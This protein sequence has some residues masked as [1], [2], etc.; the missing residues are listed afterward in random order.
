M[1]SSGS[2]AGQ[3]GDASRGNFADFDALIGEQIEFAHKR[4]RQSRDV[5]HDTQLPPPHA[6]VR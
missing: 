3:I 6:A 5:R 1:M 4:A 2:N